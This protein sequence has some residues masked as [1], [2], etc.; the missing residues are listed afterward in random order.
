MVVERT[1]E[2][3]VVR[4]VVVP[5]TVVEKPVTEIVVATAAPDPVTAKL[6]I[7]SNSSPHISVINAETNQVIRTADIPNF[8]SWTCN[9]HNNYFDGTNL[10]V[11]M[12]DAATTDVEVVALNLDTLAIARRFPIGQDPLT[13]YIRKPHKNGVL[14]VGKTGSG[15]VVEIDTIG[16]QVLDT[17]DVPV[18][19]DVVWTRMFLLAPTASSGFSIRLAVAAPWSA[20]MRKPARPSKPPRPPVGRLPRPHR[21]L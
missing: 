19:G 16:L 11:G 18:N 15:Q 7:L 5:Q 20:S 21:G 9:D 14:L 8:T 17:W 2:V 3:P 6:F 12:K 1:V 13:I 4:T 10:W